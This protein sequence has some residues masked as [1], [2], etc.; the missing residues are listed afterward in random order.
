MPQSE[1]KAGKTG[2]SFR[3]FAPLYRRIAHC[4][5]EFE[6][7]RE[8]REALDPALPAL[9]GLLFKNVLEFGCGFAAP[10][11]F[12]S[13]VQLQGCTGGGTSGRWPILCV[14]GNQ[15]TL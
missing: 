4:R 2:K 11:S 5:E 13:P 8:G 15:I 6:Q 1:Q 7:D 9:S 10:S 12:R 3:S 14:K